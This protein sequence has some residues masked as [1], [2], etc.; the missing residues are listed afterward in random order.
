M[1]FFNSTRNETMPPWLWQ[2][3]RFGRVSLADT[4][5]RSRL[6]QAQPEPGLQDVDGDG[7]TDDGYPRFVPYARDILSQLPLGMVSN[8]FEWTPEGNNV[9]QVGQGHLA[10]LP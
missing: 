9:A 5:R 10:G 7:V 4:I 1:T 2:E 3:N 8:S 6:Y